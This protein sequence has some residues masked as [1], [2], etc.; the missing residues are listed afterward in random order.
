[1]EQQQQQ[2][3]SAVEM[4]LLE[5]KEG[6]GHFTE[7][8]PDIAKKYNAFTEA[9]FAKGKLSQKEKQMI[10]LGISVFSQDEYCIIYHTKGC[11]DQGCTEDEILEAVGVT[12]AFGG[13]AAMSQAVTLVQEAMTDLSGKGSQMQQ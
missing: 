5:Y 7:K 11:L 4:A 2:N 6:L 1:M 10:A 8:M 3:Q 13:G 12:A 9:C